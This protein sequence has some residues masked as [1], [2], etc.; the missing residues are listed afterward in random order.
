[1]AVITKVGLVATGIGVA[2]VLENFADD[3][4]D[5]KMDQMQSQIESL[6]VVVYI[7]A[8]I[9]A[10]AVV[11]V[12]WN[13]FGV[14][15]LKDWLKE[16]AARVQ[17]LEKEAF[18]P[19]EK[20]QP[21][22]FV[23]DF[24]PEP[25]RS[26]RAP[27]EGLRQVENANPMN[28]MK[29]WNEISTTWASR[30]ALGALLFI[31]VSFRLGWRLR[32]R[33]HPAAQARRQDQAHARVQAVQTNRQA[34]V[35]APDGPPPDQPEVGSSSDVG[36]SWNFVEQGHCYLPSHLF[37]VHAENGEQVPMFAGQLREG[38]QV[39]A[40]NGEVVKVRY[41]PEEHQASEVIKLEAGNACL[42]V[43]PEHRIPVPGGGTCKA[44]ELSVGMPVFLQGEV[45]A[46]LTSVYRQ[47][48]TT[49]V[50]KIAFTPDLH[51]CGFMTLPGIQSKGWRK[52]QLRRS[53]RTRPIDADN[54]SLPATG[55]YLTD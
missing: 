30:L 39:V 26:T 55:G 42:V 27:T 7:L 52:K 28:P 36:S 29:S 19:P 8:L 1:M 32:H 3:K 40:A 45:Q 17:R 44:Q 46:P 2:K 22:S 4:S 6:L 41:T 53:M 15:K 48:E 11:G 35:P 16:L 54:V 9:A 14:Q 34:A 25:P 37:M 5:S 38:T 18:P 12:L 47:Q 50:L 43:S 13:I 31:A 10:I 51:V 24:H 20:P 33:R 23:Q 21:P 49:R